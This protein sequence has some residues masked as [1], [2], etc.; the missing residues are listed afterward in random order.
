[1]GLSG[2]FIGLVVGLARTTTWDFFGRGA[3]ARQDGE[4]V[5]AMFPGEFGLPWAKMV[6]RRVAQALGAGK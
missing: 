5:S 4:L 6:E 2:E 3:R 1:M